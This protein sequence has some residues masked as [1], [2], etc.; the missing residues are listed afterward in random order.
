MAIT[1]ISKILV[2]KLTH[3]RPD[4]SSSLT[5]VH[6][7]RS[8][9]PRPQA[10]Q[11]FKSITWKCTIGHAKQ[12]FVSVR[13]EGTAPIDWDKGLPI[14]VLAIIGGGREETKS[15]REVS[16]TWKAGFERGVHRLKILLNSP[17]LSQQFTDTVHQRFQVRTGPSVQL[18]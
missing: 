6:A 17:V 4:T 12:K 14:D 7:P 15:M 16:K 18:L 9:H 13:R 2:T 1:C 3:Q 11:F 10:L 5:P 8:Q